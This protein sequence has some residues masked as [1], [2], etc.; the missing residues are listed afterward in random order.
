VSDTGVVVTTQ[1][2]GGC[3]LSG[4]LTFATV[5]QLWRE[6]QRGGLL[7]SA[8]MAD[9]SAVSDADSAGLALLVAWRAHRRAAGA[10]VGFV[11]PP[12][13]LMAL[14]RLT[15]AETILA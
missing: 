4:E 2:G 10:D 12:A 3:A 11:A 1:S 9:L 14:A 15:G 6:L 13:R 5:P 8:T 7:A